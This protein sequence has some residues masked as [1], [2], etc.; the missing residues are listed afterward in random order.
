M[1]WNERI[2]IIV[3]NIW[4]WLCVYKLNGV[5]YLKKLLKISP[6]NRSFVASEKYYRVLFWIC[7]LSSTI[8]MIFG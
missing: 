6:E 2:L 1:S 8:Y 4:L 3:L 5:G 7:C